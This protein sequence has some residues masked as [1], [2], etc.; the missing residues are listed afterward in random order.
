MKFS[1][2]SIFFVCCAVSVFAADTSIEVAGGNR[3]GV[4]I[5]LESSTSAGKAFAAALK[6]NLEISGSFTIAPA[7]GSV[8]VSGTPGLSVSAIEGTQS[9]TTSEAFADEKDARMAARRFADKMVEVFSDSKTAKGFATTRVAF[10]NRMGAN[11]AELYTCYVDG[12]DIRRETSDEVAALGPRWA[13]N[14]RDIY[15]TSFLGK[16]GLVYWLDTSSHKRAC[17][18]PFKGTASGGAVS[19]DG[20]YCALVATFNGNPELYVMELGPRP[21]KIRRLTQTKDATEASPCWS[22]DG[23]KI[24]YVS[25]ETR[26]PQIYVIDVATK[27]KTRFTSQGTENTEPDWSPNGLLVWNSKRA[28]QSVIVYADAVRGESTSAVVTEPGT[29]EH[30]SWT[31]DGR[32][33]VASRDKAL[34]LVDTVP[35]PE[36]DKP[37]QIF[38]N[39]GNWINPTCSR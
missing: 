14:G 15:Y 26:R 3:R 10:I 31:R 22:P 16:T 25:D 20:K 32:H 17:L 39:G 7:S 38:R 21:R 33:L 37:R 9:V 6:R 5:R 24:A 8:K 30:P 2:L 4:D 27:K 19:P 34:F 36:G 11:R 1:T 18:E 28:G 29:W 13:P 35:Y 23:T 12:F